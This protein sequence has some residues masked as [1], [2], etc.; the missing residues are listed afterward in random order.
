MYAVGVLLPRAGCQLT[1]LSTLVEAALSLPAASCTLLAGIVTITSP[2]VVIP[3]TRTSHVV[4]SNGASCETFVT[5]V[6]PAVLPEVAGALL[7]KP[8]TGSLKTAVKWIGAVLVGSDWVAA[9][10]IVTNEAS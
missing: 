5:S 3:F 6:P 9:W 4:P 1:V 2:A 7:P 10:L 8:L